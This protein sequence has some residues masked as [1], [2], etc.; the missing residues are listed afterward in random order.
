MSH[1]IR[2]PL[3]GVIGFTELLKGTPLSEVQKEYVN[4]ANVSG[5]A[6]LGIIN[7][8]LDFSKIEAGMLHLERIRTDMV[9]LLE[10][11]VDIVKYQAEKKGIE[12]LLG[13]DVNMPRFATV[14]PIRLKQVLA[15]LLGN[16]VKFTEKGEVVL[17]V[18]YEPVEQGK[19]KLSFF[20]RDTGIGISESQ[21]NKLFKA[22]SQA[23]SSTTRKFGGTGLGLVIAD[24][25][26]KE[27]GGKI[28]VD[29]KPGVG[30]TFYFDIITEVAE[31]KDYNIPCIS[32]IK[33]CLII[34]D[35]A[36]N[37][38]ILEKMLGKWGIVCE[39]CDNGL[40][41]LKLLQTSNPFD[42]IICDYNMPYMD[43][44]ETI[45]IIRERLNL[46]PDKQPIIVLHSSSDD[47]ELHRRCDALGVRFRLT[48][49]VKSRDLYAYLCQV[50]ESDKN[51]QE[52][53]TPQDTTTKATVP[54][55][56]CILIAEDVE[57]NMVMI[58]ALIARIFPN[59]VLHK[60]KNGLE[61][62]QLAK[63]VV[64]DLILMDVQMPEMDGLEA[65]RQIRLMETGTDRH[66]PI[67][68]LTAGAFKEE[69][70]KCFAVGMD[71]FLTKPVEKE[72]IVSVLEK[73]LSA[74]GSRAEG[75]VG[76]DS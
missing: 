45:R 17:N 36:N 29:S 43:G 19:G 20:V 15:N 50:H 4:N 26:I 37:R 18:E 51:Y 21:M 54:G 42:V 39:T 6:L 16:A 40:T 56:A 47:A 62:I 58:T 12:L 2:T 22:F 61:A 71:D 72:K 35:N 24:M 74:K 1:E 25:I 11:S 32:R 38:L 55:S 57:M 9:E 27:M 3:N 68:A 73:Y 23:D 52:T 41:A 7:D 69:R 48:K 14:D 66:V 13:I 30:S 34:D 70:E 33:R 63:E 49:P 5:H 8:I 64:P 44:L 31:A 46:T 60:A 59:A 28:K 53:I 65:T 76:V 10:N 75:D 67:I